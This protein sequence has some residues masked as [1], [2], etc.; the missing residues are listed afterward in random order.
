MSSTSQKFIDLIASEIGLSESDVPKL[1]HW[2]G[3]GTSIGALTLRLGLLDI[4]KINELLEYAYENEGLF[5]ENAVK[6]GYLNEAQV[7]RLLLLQ[8]WNR[9]VQVVEI[10]KVN[11]KLSNDQFKYYL[12]KAAEDL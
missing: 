3:T 2:A 1:G 9:R 5:G 7:E 11:G 8:R 6:L 12:G 10:L 4:N